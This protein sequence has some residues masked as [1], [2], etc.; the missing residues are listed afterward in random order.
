VFGMDNTTS[1]GG[2]PSHFCAVRVDGSLWCWGGDGNGQLGD[3]SPQ[4]FQAAPTRVLTLASPVT[5][6][7]GGGEHTCALLQDG[8]VWCWGLGSS[9]QL[10]ENATTTRISPIQVQGL[11]TGVVGIALGQN[12]TCAYKDDGSVWCWGANGTGQV[13]DGTQVNKLVPTQ[14]IAPCP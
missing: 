1:I 6:M 10:G 14:V 12:H 8:T 9:G 13:G 4:G 3:G 7:D 11:G 2:G 5:V